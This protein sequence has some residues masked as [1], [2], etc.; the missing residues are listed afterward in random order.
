M[1]EIKINTAEKELYYQ[2]EVILTYRIEYPEIIDSD[3]KLG[4]QI[5]NH[6][7][8]KAALDLK[9]FAEGELYEEAKQ[10]YEYNKKNGY[11]IMIYELVQECNITYNKK[12]LVSL[13][14]DEYTFTGGAHGNTI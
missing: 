6:E 9:E 3:Y 2:G 11:P 13:Y 5:F 7:N 10:T 12:Q 4:M 14:C 8:R 1:N